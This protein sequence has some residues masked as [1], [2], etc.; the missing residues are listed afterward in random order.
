MRYLSR[1]LVDAGVE[2]LDGAG[3]KGDILD[4]VGVDFALVR[5]GV[6]RPQLEEVA[7]VRFELLKE[8]VDRA[9]ERGEVVVPLEHGAIGEDDVFG[10]VVD[11]R[12]VRPVDVVVRHMERAVVG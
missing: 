10:V 4:G 8:D 1:G 12:D 2:V 7:M 11:G 3:E 6:G 5:V 9:R